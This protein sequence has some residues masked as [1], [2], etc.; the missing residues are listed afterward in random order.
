MKLRK[1]EIKVPKIFFVA[2]WRN[3]IFYQGICD[4]L[5][6][7]SNCIRKVGVV[8]KESERD[9]NEEFFRRSVGLFGNIVYLC[10]I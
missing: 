5:G 8:L 7:N 6:R 4:F 10:T 3:F 2:Q 1:K 9:E